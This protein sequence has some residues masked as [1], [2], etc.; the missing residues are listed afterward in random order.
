MRRVFD[1]KSH[2]K[3]K[4]HI[5]L[6]LCCIFLLS[7]CAD[8]VEECGTIRGNM[9]SCLLCSFFNEL[10]NTAAS[11]AD[12]SWNKFAKNLADLVLIVSAIYVALSVLKMVGAFGKQTVADFLTSDKNGLFIFM[13]K[14]AVIWY[15]LANGLGNIL[16]YLISPLFSSAIDITR[17]ISSS[18]E[19]NSNLVPSN[20]SSSWGSIFNKMY[21]IVK[22][23]SDEI[24]VIISMGETMACV[25]T[26][27]EL[28]KW[29]FLLLIYGALI[30]IF[31]W[32]LMVG[33]SF[34]L[35]DIMIRLLFAAVLLPLG[36]ACAIS[37]LSVAY[38]KNIWNL[39]LNVFFALI[40]LG[41]IL[42]IILK[43]ILLCLGQSIGDRVLGFSNID[44]DVVATI[45]ANQIDVLAEGLQGF[46]FLLLTIV[47]FSIIF[48]LVRQLD[49]LTEKIS[50][51]IG[52]SPASEAVAPFAQ[53]SIGEGKRMGKWAKGVAGSAA[54]Q[55]GHDLARGFRLDK[56]YKWSGNKATGIRGYMTGTGSQGYKA[57]WRR[58]K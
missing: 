24:A 26:V 10:R 18:T 53:A 35:V 49:P 34:Y 42:N 57:F 15:L 33:M 7:S 2:F 46:G 16:Q 43:I 39:F 45:D 14:T 40:M 19:L 12:S 13:F 50:E 5:F 30:F 3:R 25:A 8:E 6:A 4:L 47:A 29:K 27:P 51:V 44:F 48:N 55:L 31:G 54:G 1:I 38:T 28:I 21:D 23:F 36:I 22:K 9:D 41:I 32:I 52:F 56:L 20:F 37:K 11:M 58:R 17:S